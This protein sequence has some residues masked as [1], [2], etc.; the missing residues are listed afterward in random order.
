MTLRAASRL[1]A[2]LCAF[3]AKVGHD[4]GDMMVAARERRVALE[5]R[6]GSGSDK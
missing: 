1:L 4:A 2:A 5:G 3:A 6:S